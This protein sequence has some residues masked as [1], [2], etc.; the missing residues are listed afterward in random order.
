MVWQI[1]LYYVISHIYIACK[2]FKKKTVGALAEHVRFPCESMFCNLCSTLSVEVHRR[3]DIL[4]I[5]CY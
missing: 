2:K 3:L 4:P 1:D 5:I